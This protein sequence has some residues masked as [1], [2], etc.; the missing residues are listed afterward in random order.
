[1]AEAWSA[2]AVGLGFE[3][4]PNELMLQSR[5]ARGLCKGIP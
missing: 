2:V 1:M 4:N 3:Q 5:L